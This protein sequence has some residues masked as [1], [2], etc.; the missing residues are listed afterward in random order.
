MNRRGFVGTLTALLVGVLT[1][2]WFQARPGVFGRSFLEDAIASQDAY[3]AVFRTYWNTGAF[4]PAQ[5]E[6]PL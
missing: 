4:R 2:R 6:L 3:T 5:L 1:P